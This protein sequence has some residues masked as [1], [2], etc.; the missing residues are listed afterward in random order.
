MSRPGATD[1]PG[2]P[3]GA[4]PADVAGGYGG[5]VGLDQ[6]LLDYLD[7]GG[8]AHT[9][10]VLTDYPGYSVIDAIISRYAGVGLTGAVPSGVAGK[11]VDDYQGSTAGGTK[12]ERPGQG[13][14]AVAGAMQDHR[15]GGGVSRGSHRG[16]AEAV[17]EGGIGAVHDDQCCETHSGGRRSV[18]PVPG[19][20]ETTTSLGWVCI[21][22]GPLKRLRGV[23]PARRCTH[24]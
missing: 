22:S 8:I 18:R 4:G 10:V 1:R 21:L 7:S 6:R 15:R 3:F 5:G 12:S 16:R 9:G 24:Q 17:V 20:D 11:C 23:H 14:L 2:V 13:L 19:L